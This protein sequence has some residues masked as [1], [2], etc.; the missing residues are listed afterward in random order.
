MAMPL[1]FETHLTRRN[2]DAHRFR[3]QGFVDGIGDLSGEVFLELRTPAEVIDNAHETTEPGDMRARDVCYRNRSKKWHEMV[4]TKAIERQFIERD[5]V[6]IW[7]GH[8]R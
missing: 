6:A 7:G 2:D 1:Q 4:P 5:D 8:E 3:C